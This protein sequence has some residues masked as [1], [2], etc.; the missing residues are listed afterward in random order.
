MA[1]GR[2]YY[3]TAGILICALMYV[4]HIKL[5]WPEKAL[6]AMSGSK[7]TTSMEE[8][9][10]ASETG[11]EHET[12]ADG[13]EVMGSADGET[14]GDAP[15]VDVATASGLALRERPFPAPRLE[16]PRSG[17]KDCFPEIRLGNL[18]KR[19]A[20]A[21]PEK[22]NTGQ[23][24]PLPLRLDSTVEST[25][26]RPTKRARIE[27][28]L[29][30]SYDEAGTPR[31]STFTPTFAL[32]SGRKIFGSTRLLNPDHRSASKKP[33]SLISAFCRSNDLLMLLTSYLT[34]PSLLSL[35]AIS[36]PFHYLFNGAYTAFILSNMRTWA[37][38][39]DKIY[40]WRFYQTLCL[41][42]PRLRQKSKWKDYDA[43]LV[44]ED[45]RDIP[46]LQWLQMVVWRQGV[47]KDMLIQ[48]AT[49]G[50]RCPPGT[51]EAIRRMWFVMDLPLN[52]HRI[53]IVQNEEYI[54]QTT[55]FRATQFFLEVDMHFT[56]PA[57]PIYPVNTPHMNP[58]V[59]LP[60]WQNCGLVGCSLRALLTAERHFTSLWRALRGVCPDP[61][62]EMYP[63]E[64]L[65][66]LRLWVRHA[67]HL[68]ATTAEHVKRQSIL[69]IP[70]NEVGTAGLERTGV[71]LHQL[72]DG[73]QTAIIHPAVTSKATLTTAIEKQFLYPHQKRLLVPATTQK[74][75]EPLLRPEELMMREGIRRQM[76]LHT[77]WSRMML[78][79]FCDDLGRNLPLRSEADL[80][81]WSHG[82]EPMSYYRTDDQ[83]LEARKKSKAAGG[84]NAAQRVMQ[85]PSVA[86]TP[87][88]VTSGTTG[89]AG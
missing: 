31:V 43:R 80:I 11:R 33:F 69:G 28:K 34:L 59:Y 79:G 53:A 32:P 35:Y 45:L 14:S 74:P 41:K 49:H 15:I 27:N 54:T 71:S 4:S 72:A 88:L 17:L 25:A 57:G 16:A 46:S 26:G 70:W 39:A 21:S 30:I 44:H 56:D 86:L 78:W 73:S 36:K 9:G 23:F 84:G 75:R 5:E 66:V 52:A 64:R 20:S 8:V 48:L 24:E 58:A 50:L 38:D 89:A 42:D 67:Y 55:I 3:Y 82:K 13:A 63:I 51:L 22:F 6:W 81:K 87:G 76:R 18:H 68:P 37:P 2:L 61:G 12:R 40:P 60:Q 47:C 29:E 1:V 7:D 62:E 85:S 10:S 65:D 19:R 83:V 77:H